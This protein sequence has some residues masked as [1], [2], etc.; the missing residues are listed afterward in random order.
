MA[1]HLLLNGLSGNLQSN[2]SWARQ[3]ALEFIRQTFTRT[4]ASLTPSQQQDYVRLQREAL[5]ALNAVDKANT[6]LIDAF[7]TDGLVQLRSKLGGLDPEA[8]FLHTRYLEEVGA[9]QPW[10]PRTSDILPLAGQRFR[11]AFDEWMYRAH[12]STMSLWDAACLNFDFATEVKHK[13]GH[14]FVDSTYLTGVNKQQLNVQRFIAIS[15]E[16]DLGGQLKNRLETVLGPGGTLQA[17]IQASAR[18]CLRFEALEA[19]RNRASTGVTWA[20]HEQLVQ[21]IDGSGPALG[22]DTLSMQTGPYETAVPLP[23][24]LIRVASLGV[25][26]Y[27]PFRPGGALHFHTDAKAAGAQFLADL[28][29]GQR[30]R[31]LGWFSRQLPM[32]QMHA[33]KQLLSDESRPTGLSPAAGFLYD[34]FHHWFPERTVDQLRFTNDPQSGPGKT[35][36]QAFAAR[37]VQRYQANLSTLATTR[38]ERDLQAVIDGA[39]AVADEVLQLLLTP[40]PGGVTGLNRIMQAVVF[41]SLS[42]SLVAGITQAAQGEASNF[43]AALTDVADLAVNGLLISTAGRVHRLRM[44]GLLQR[45]GNPRKVQR[46]D[47]EFELWKPDIS[48]FA[49]LDQHLLN[50]QVANPQGVYQVNGNQYVWLIQDQQRQVVQVQLDPQSQRFVLK[51]HNGA[52]FAP[53]IIFNPAQQAWTLDLQGAHTLSDVQLAERMLPNGSSAVPSTA[54]ERMLRSTSTT[55]ATLDRIWAGEPAP[56]HL[57]ESVRRLQVDQVIKQLIHDFHRRGHMPPYADS[58]VLCLLTQLETWPRDC[59]IRIYDQAGT[60]METYAGSRQLPPAVQFIDLTRRDDGTYLAFGDNTQD[61]A[62]QEQLFELIMTGQP[63]DSTLGKEGSAH[64]TLAQRIA[65]VRVQIS[66]L[67][68]ARQIELFSAMTR[69]AGKAREQVPA[70]DGASELV[71]IK[72]ASP[73]VEVTPLLQKLHDLYPPLTPANL[74]QLLVQTPLTAAQQS[75]FLSHGQLPASVQRHLE[76]QRTALRIDAV[77]DGLYHPRAYHQDTDQWAREFASSLVRKNL[78][79]HFV[80]TEMNNGAPADR[81]VSSGPNDTTV[82]LLHYGEGRYQAYDMRNGGPIP[83]SPPA[84]SFY[85]AIGSVL[86]PH[87]RT[88]LGMRSAA[89]AQGLRQTLGDLMSTQRSPDG[90]VSLLDNSLAQYEQRI[91]LPTDLLPNAQ[92]LYEYQGQ[93]LVP[94]YGSLY[95]VVF[96]NTL[97]KWRLKHPQKV[98]VQTPRLE[99]NG[100]GAWRLSSE[101]PMTWDDHRLFYRLGPQ[102]YNV[103]QPTAAR[104][105]RIT[106][107]PPSALRQV[108]SANLPP[109]PLLADTS[110]R[111]RIEREIESFIQAMTTYSAKGN[112]RP[113]LQLLLACALPTWPAS[114]VLHVV[115]SDGQIIRSFPAA[116]ARAPNI[117]R[118][119][120]EQSRGAEPLSAIVRNDTVARA[121]LDELPESLEERL[122]KLGKKIAEYAHRERTQLFDTLYTQSESNGTTAL[123]RRLRQHYPNLPGSALDAMLEQASPREL[124]QLHEHDEV[125]L[126]LAEQARLSANDVR[127]NRAF[128]GLYLRT[129]RNPDSEKIILHLLKSAAGWPANTRLDIHLVDAN[130]ALLNSA[131]HLDGS[132]RKVLANVDGRYLAYDQQGQL[133]GD[134]AE[135][136]FGALSLVLGGVELAPLQNSIADAALNQRIAIKALLDIPHIPHWLQPPM[137]LDT[138]FTAY[139]FSLSNLWPF[140]SQQPVDLVSKVLELY[141]S[142][143]RAAAHDLIDDLGMSDP[144]A[145]IELQRRKAE[146]QALDHGLTRWADAPHANDADDPLGLNLG[147]RR[148][149]AQQIRRAW[150][151]ETGAPYQNGL[152]D[153][154]HLVVQLDGNDLP[155]PDFILGTRGFEHIESLRLMADEFPATGN[156][157][158]SKFVNLKYLQVDCQLTE[159]PTSITD[160]TQLEHLDLSFNDIRLTVEARER[161]R[162]LT[163]LEE[164]H[165][166]GNSLVLTPDVSTMTRLRIL[167]LRGTGITQWPIGAERRPNMNALLLQDNSITHVPPVLYTDARMRLTNRNTYLHGNDLSPDTWLRLDE[168]RQSTGIR[169]GGAARGPQHAPAA[170]HEIDQWLAGVPATEHPKRKQLWEQLRANESVHADDVFEVLRD[171]PNTYAYSASSESRQAL[172]TRVWTLLLAMADSTELRNNVCL[173]TYGAGDCGDSV[174]LAFTKME[175]ELR[176]HQAKAKTRTYESDRDLLKLATG[177]FYLNQLDEFSARF[178]ERREM[179]ALEVDP[180]EVTIYMRA[181]L[182]DEFDLPFHPLELLYTVDTYV[183]DTVLDDARTELRRLGASSALQEWLLME[184][185]WIEYLARSH[186]EPFSTVKDSIKHKVRQLDKELTDKRSEDYLERRQSLVDLEQAELNRLVRQLTLATQAALQHA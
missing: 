110:K 57:I 19:Y 140:S 51:Q 116:N 177:R 4:L 151:R 35:L 76:H 70:T 136:L 141:P 134:T 94:L 98:G 100:L 148:F 146:Y 11:R 125:G 96:D 161:L 81:Y 13:T 129:Q 84:D 3:Q 152:F 119:S 118:M 186:P 126:R 26:S 181:Q 15:R 179:A 7:K 28:K 40:I 115:D 82:E 36:V 65:R 90:Y 8:I 156:A 149:V 91:V 154:H 60:P 52:S 22:F 153:A 48:P 9:P 17:L 99:H 143:N 113:A 117:I 107:T 124:K 25:L 75:Q 163:R 5:H 122:F 71:P 103:D 49:T 10:E 145:L 139:P 64:L 147:R 102:D 158:L 166:D 68:K 55:R 12:V 2:E 24:L 27:F 173:N 123:Q 182:A 160:M 89:D 47:G 109:P 171:L 164:L 37:Q 33:F 34:T 130:G 86:Q 54:M 168:Y 87:E 108:H 43:A 178:I 92:G 56:V 53:P 142:L 180:A 131:G 162:S 83:V 135:D 138:S 14:S 137:A 165:L 74:Q 66:A 1:T 185:F 176:I 18:A 77:I 159:L 6:E 59:A 95:P 32:S 144:A 167:S 175:L 169:L 120:F 46:A 132:A 157:F 88:Q 79:R 69:H 85:L 106:G 80:V 172:T 121:L 67:A 63:A 101:N 45:L 93:Q 58:S 127:L 50:G 20:L 42:Y 62:R 61:V 133:L 183:T 114:H 170:P 41:G 174:L 150:R 105:L 38:S 39:A 21:A 97:L 44:E 184:G 155:D 78:G 16:L 30:N 31:D 128:E 111:F 112:A 73:L 72:V 23:L 29:L 104:I